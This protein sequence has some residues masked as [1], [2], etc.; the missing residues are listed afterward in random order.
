MESKQ[1]PTLV[2]FVFRY[3]KAVPP[4]FKS[5]ILDPAQLTHLLSIQGEEL[6]QYAIFLCGPQG[7]AEA[8]KCVDI[9][10]TSGFAESA[11]I[12]K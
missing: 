3:H 2:H 6:K 4:Y 5:K 12:Y 8:I 1:L 10:I 9:T 11:R 7:S